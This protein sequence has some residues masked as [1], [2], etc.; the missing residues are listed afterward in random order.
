MQ[1]H[2]GLSCELHHAVNYLIYLTMT[3][4]HF[5]RFYHCNLCTC[6]GSSSDL[7]EKRPQALFKRS[8]WTSDWPRVAL[9]AERGTTAPKFFSLAIVS[10]AIKSCDVVPEIFFY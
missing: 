8:Y 6:A 10:N 4:D 7:C 2:Y 3:L 9:G 5:G 1:C